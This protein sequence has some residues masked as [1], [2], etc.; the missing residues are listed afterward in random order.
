MISMFT[1]STN[2]FA[3]SSSVSHVQPKLLQLCNRYKREKQGGCGPQHLPAMTN[4][5]AFY[6]IGMPVAVSLAFNSKFYAQVT[7]HIICTSTLANY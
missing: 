6:M 1:S 4:L 5:A 7:N 2:M 3:Y